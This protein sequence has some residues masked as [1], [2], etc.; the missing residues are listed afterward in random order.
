MSLRSHFILIRCAWL[1]KKMQKWTKW[2]E[3]WPIIRRNKNE[4][5]ESDGKKMRENNMK[6][7]FAIHFVNSTIYSVL[8]VIIL[9]ISWLFSRDLLSSLSHFNSRSFG[10][11]FSIIRTEGKWKLARARLR[12]DAAQTAFF[13]IN[14]NSWIIFDFECFSAFS[15]K[16]P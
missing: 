6:V 5:N 3:K 4:L 15:Q 12:L 10:F 16:I 13:W 14:L 9:F 1:R 7:H 2:I 11:D 8:H